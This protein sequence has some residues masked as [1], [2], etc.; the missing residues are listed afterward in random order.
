MEV[1]DVP[2]V[3]VPANTLPIVRL[4]FLLRVDE[5]LKALVEGAV[6]LEHV[7]DVEF[8]V[9]A[10][11]DVRDSE[12]EPLGVRSSVVVVQQPQVVF[13]LS[14]LLGS[15]QVARLEPGFKD[16]SV[17]VVGLLRVVGSEFRVVTVDLHNLG[18]EAHRGLAWRPIRVVLS[19]INR[20]LVLRNLN[21]VVFV[22]V[23]S[24]RSPVSILTRRWK[25]E[26]VVHDSVIWANVVVVVLLGIHS[27]VLITHLL[28]KMRIDGLVCLAHI[29]E[30]WSL[31]HVRILNASL[32]H[33]D[34]RSHLCT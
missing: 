32:W 10:L 29:I 12:V 14:D 22:N 17:V 26:S 3:S 8:V 5:R 13:V 18:I 9:E 11:F 16:Q 19:L 21:E 27:S 34:H 20:V 28:V 1:E 7:D 31:S 4:S 25:V 15:S 23:W 30:T 24:L 2:A 33:F 6:R